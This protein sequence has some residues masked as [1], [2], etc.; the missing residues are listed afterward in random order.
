MNI[1]RLSI[2]RPIF[3]SSIVLVIVFTGFIAITR[4]GVD[5]YPDV[6]FPFVMVQTVYQGAA[7][8][9][10]ENLISKPMEDQIS[11][12][13]GLK[14]VTSRNME[15]LSF[16]FAE[17]NLGEDI[18][19]AEQQIKDKIGLI[20]KDLPDGIEEPVISR[21]DPA[22]FPVLKISVSADLKPTDLYDLAK[23]EIKTSIQQVKDVAAVDIIGG[24]RREIQVEL[25]RKK[26]NEYK[27]SAVQVI[28]Q[29]K[30]AG[31]NVPVG[32]YEK[33][34]SETIFRTVAQFKSLEQIENTVI[35][36]TGDVDSSVTVNSLGTVRD[37]AEDRKTI[38]YLYAPVEDKAAGGLFHKSKNVKRESHPAL[39]LDVYKQSGS[40]T[41]SVVNGVVDRIKKINEKMNGQPGNPKLT[42]VYDGAYFIRM[43]VED[44]AITI[45]LGILLAVVVVYLFLGNIR[46]TIITGIAIPNSLLG[47]FVLM[48]AM[49]YTINVVTLLALSLT[50]GLLIDD[51]IVVRENIFRKLE[52]GM[53]PG[54]AA[55]KGTT[56]V[57]LAVVATTLTI[58]AV[59]FPIAFLSGIVGQ[60]FKEFGFTIIFA[61]AIS[62]F[63]ALTVAPFL[64]A[65]F[66]GKAHVTQNIV[67]RMFERFQRKLESWYG[68]I[69]GY[70]LDHPIKVLLITTGIFI[71]SLFSITTV[72]GT[73]MP[74]SDWGE[75]IVKIEMPP[76]T[77][78]DGTLDAALKIG[79][80]IKQ[81]LPEL[82]KMSTVVGTQQQETNVAQLGIS[83][84]DASERKRNATQ[85]KDSLRKILQKEFAYAKPKVNEFSMGGL[86]MQYPFYLNLIGNDLESLD[87]YSH[88]LVQ[89]IK[90]IPDLTD[91]DSSS[92]P[93]KPEYQIKLDTGR[94]QM[95]GV[96]SAVAGA[97]LRYQIA[98]EVAGKLHD[99]GLEYD[100]RVRLKPEQRDL[101]SAYRETRV[102]NSMMRLIPLS[103]IG[104]GI[105]KEG[106]SLI[107]RENRSR[108]VQIFGNLAP[109]GAVGNAMDQTKRILDR[110]MPPPKGI[111]YAFVGQAQD[112]K[113]MG[114]NIFFA[115]ILSVVFIYFILAALYESFVTPLTIL[116]ALPPALSGAFLALAVM[117]E[118]LNIYSMIGM[119]MLMG[120][121]TKN[122]ILLVDFALEG[123]RNGM[124]RKQA[125]FQAGKIRLRP[126]LMT[127]F[128]MLAGTLPV[129]LGFGEISKFRTAMGVAIIGG[130]ILS[131]FLTLV[132]VP[133]MFEYVDTF[134]EFIESKFRPK[135]RMK[136]AEREMVGTE[137]ENIEEKS[138]LI[139]RATGTNGDVRPEKYKKRLK[140]T[141]KS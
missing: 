63:D 46:S 18:K 110:E 80:R 5:L 88:R 87:E 53:N 32:K 34:T 138:I 127:T 93:G 30:N 6:T 83:L 92:Q 100:V 29:L 44:V 16:V 106:P 134:R 61:M 23:E 137:E 120:L 17:F 132:V 60:F 66:A 81:V 70:A 123:V 89:K 115:V 131:T 38:G 78:L 20:R 21:F 124:S 96:S 59:F 28:S 13:S 72:K 141:K 98:G 69:M 128:A 119:V 76:G 7:P 102:P 54:E 114:R 52:S 68:K 43:N 139:V 50:V 25:D 41:V 24:R 3:I 36:F 2:K 112:Y 135:Y 111:T 51:A 136:T 126:I 56:E 4:L 91:V 77:S 140:K 99:K 42:L 116:M 48:Y 79:D 62:L 82:N 11:S 122:S 129:A 75:F 101:R 31:T 33:G 84:V 35:N 90:K 26:L 67:V 15:S 73:F 45:L 49:G 133:A 118:M 14:K 55:E 125:I 12:I 9:E 47:A 95:L 64:S 74:T 71:I 10:I 39:F 57:M 121:V 40:N 19:Y 8:E 130:L 107:I 104:R 117:R 37:G 97:E 65:Y 109:G 103:A 27:I 108:V 86:G 94:M 113:E 1:A 58:I 105:E 22:D 85:I